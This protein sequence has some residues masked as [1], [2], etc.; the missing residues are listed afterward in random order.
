M[1]LTHRGQPVY[2]I[3]LK[4][5]DVELQTWTSV[6]PCHR[7]LLCSRRLKLRLGLVGKLRCSFLTLRTDG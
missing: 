2:H 7:P 1:S 3:P 6:S 5:Y 4:V